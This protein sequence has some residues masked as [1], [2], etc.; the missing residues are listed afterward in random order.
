VTDANLILGR[1]SPDSPLAGSLRLDLEAARVAIRKRVAGPLNLDVADAALGMLRIVNA[2]MVRAIRV[3]SVE[4][5]YDPRDFT[6]VAFG[7]AGPMHDAHLAKE[8]GIGRVLV[9]ES[10][11]ILCALGLLYADVR[12]DFGRTALMKHH[13]A[14]PVRINDLFAD[15]EAEALRWLD[16]EQLPPGE[17]L[18]ERRVDMRYVGQDYELPVPAPAGTLGEADLARLEAAFHEAHAQAYGYSAADAPTELVSFRVALRVPAHP[19]RLV[20][21]EPGGP[22]PSAAQK[23][24]RP[25]YFEETGRFVDCPIYDRARLRPGNVIP[26]P[27]IV[28]QMDATTVILP[29]QRGI[30]D[31]LC[32]L[33]IAPQA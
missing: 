22:D 2:N 21:P 23:G 6:M 8:L 24:T 3:V 27:A 28:E 9:P 29:G 31:A 16:R 26:G 30:V 15:L 32:N 7:G 18:L 33:L 10:P 20:Q 17:A 14:R 11:G 4:R 19:P 12:A 5:G 1:L 13:A 25:V